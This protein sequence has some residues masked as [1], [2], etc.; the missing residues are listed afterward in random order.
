MAGAGLQTS[1]PVYK[2]VAKKII[3]FDNK[4]RHPLI[5]PYPLKFRTV[6][7]VVCILYSGYSCINP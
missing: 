6:R 1:H 3:H 2:I 7:S 5:Q 4:I